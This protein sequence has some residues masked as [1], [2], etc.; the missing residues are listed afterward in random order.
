M[1]LKHILLSAALFTGIGAA[2]QEQVPANS[3]F[4]FLTWPRSL[5]SVGM[6]GAGSSSASGSGAWAAFSNPAALPFAVGKLDAGLSYSR[7]APS[8]QG[9]LSNNLG[10]GVAVRLGRSFVVNAGAVYQGHASQ[11]FGQPYGTYAPS[12]LVVG[13]GAAVRIGEYVGIGVSGRY[14]QQSLLSDFSLSGFAVTAMAQFHLGG[15]NAAA[16]VANIG[17]GVKSDSGNSS[18]LPTSARLAVSYALPVGLEA[19]LDGDYYFSG[20]IGVSAG[21]QYA[22]RDR[23]FVRAGY[24]F[25]T[26]GAPLPSHLALGLGGKVFGVTLDLAFLTLNKEIGNTLAVGLGYRF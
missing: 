9:T 11:D 15:L 25:A 23:V 20:K 5:Q 16:G 19:A 12:D 2:A 26:E 4:D 8:S 22:Y 1:K 18:S 10:G 7:W 24:R 3:V 13:L 21:L 14:V 6:A 17:G